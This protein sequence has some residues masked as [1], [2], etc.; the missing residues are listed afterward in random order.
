MLLLGFDTATEVTTVALVRAGDDG[1]SHVLG[2]RSHRDARRHGEVLPVQI[3]EILRDAEVGPSDVD[4]VAVGVGPGAYT[5]LRVG[6]AT[7]DALGLALAVP[8]H[9]ASTHDV[10]AFATQRE[11]PFAVVTDA[12]RRELFW[13]TYR[14]FDSRLSPPQVGTPDAVRAAL[15]GLDVVVPPGTPGIEGLH[16]RPGEAPSAVALCRLVLSRLADG[17]VTDRPEPIYL[18]RPDVMPAAPPKSV[19][20]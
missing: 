1:V 9:G 10:L 5:G 3:D 7:A 11:R 20:S 2:E 4:A 8:I 13:S 6:L 12:R 16:V 14:T 17:Q 18:R 15:D 19:L